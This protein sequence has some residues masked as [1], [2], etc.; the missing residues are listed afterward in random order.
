MKGRVEMIGVGIDLGNPSGKLV[1]ISF[2]SEEVV[3]KEIMKSPKGI[4]PLMNLLS[5]HTC[6]L[7]VDVSRDVIIKRFHFCF[8]CWGCKWETSS[9]SIKITLSL[10][11]FSNHGGEY[12]G[13]AIRKEHEGCGGN[14]AARDWDE[15]MGIE[16]DNQRRMRDTP[17][18]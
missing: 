4:P 17:N 9:P 16:W 6:H 12:E 14:G 11:V 5:F 15:R 8:Y 13:Y 3:S 7:S 18:L 1:T 10:S 2:L